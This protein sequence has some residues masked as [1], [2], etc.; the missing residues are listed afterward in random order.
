MHRMTTGSRTQLSTSYVLQSNERIKSGGWSD[1]E[2]SWIGAK[3][4]VKSW[5]KLEK[6]ADIG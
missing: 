1:L 3:S 5:V 6:K 4:W 2:S